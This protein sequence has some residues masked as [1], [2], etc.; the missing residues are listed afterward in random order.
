MQG[1]LGCA[2]HECKPLNQRSHWSI[3][4]TPFWGFSG[5][6]SNEDS[7]AFT[8]LSRHCFCEWDSICNFFWFVSGGEFDWLWTHTSNGP[9]FFWGGGCYSRSG[10]PKR[11]GAVER[12]VRATCLWPIVQWI[13]KLKML[14]SAEKI[15]ATIR[16]LR[17]IL[18]R[19]HWC[20]FYHI[21]R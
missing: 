8:V 10:D 3:G 21:L 12:A 19:G 20:H 7:L 13:W 11:G 18:L 2:Y 16:I 6:V 5:L 15:T 4:G 1:C 9:L 14:K 17:A